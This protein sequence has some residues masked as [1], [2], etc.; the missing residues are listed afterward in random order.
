M[1]EG[2]GQDALAHQWTS[3]A[4]ASGSRAALAGQIPAPTS[5][6]TATATVA[7][8]PALD[9]TRANADPLRPPSDRELR[10]Y[11][12]RAFVVAWTAGAVHVRALGEATAP[13]AEAQVELNQL[14]QALGRALGSQRGEY[15][16]FVDVSGLGTVHPALAPDVAQIATRLPS[17]PLRVAVLAG[18]EPHGAAQLAFTRAV[19]C[20]GHRAFPAGDPRGALRWLAEARTCDAAAL[21]ELHEGG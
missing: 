20:D 18:L 7:G 11:M 2:T 1:S 15:V 10:I 21:A 12:T 13:P 16:V 3:E 6:R 4:T 5:A 19:L 17:R 8:A 14:R 9:E